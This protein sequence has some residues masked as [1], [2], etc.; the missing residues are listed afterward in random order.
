MNLR[1]F[2][3]RLQ[4]IDKHRRKVPLRLNWAQDDYISRIEQQYDSGRPGRFIILKARQMGLSTAT[5]AVL[6]VYSFLFENNKSLVIS[7]NQ[8][9]YEH[10]LS[11]SKH[12]WETFWAKRL[13]TTDY[14]SR[15][16]LAWIETGSS[17]RTATAKTVSAGRS[18]TIHSL[19]ASE[20]GFWDDAATLMTG[21]RQTIP[22][23][24]SS[25]IALESTANGIGNYFH[26]EW[27]AAVRG[28]SEYI[29]LFYPW[30]KHPEYT[31]E[32]IHTP[33]TYIGPLS[34]DER[35]LSILLSST[36]S[37]TPA[38]IDSRIIWRRHAIRNLCQNDLSIFHQEYPATPEE[39]FISTGRNVFPYADLEQCYQRQVGHRGFI[40]N[41][42]TGVP[43][44][45]P[46]P[47]GPCTIFS[48]PSSNRDYGRYFVAGDP[49]HTTRGDYACIQVINRRTLEQVARV[50]IKIDPVNFAKELIN[51]AKFY[52][53]AMISCES[54]GPG[55][56]TIGAILTMGYPNVWQNRFADKLQGAMPDQYGF[57]TNV[58][59]KNWAIGA[60]LNLIVEHQIIIHDPI[61]FDELTN[62]ISLDNGTYGP[63]SSNG[64]DDTVMALAIAVI[65]HLTEPPLPPMGQ[66]TPSGAPWEDW[67]L[68]GTLSEAFQNL[69]QGL[70][71][72]AV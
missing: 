13:F 63:A 44:F 5:E 57:A 4:I 42:G 68:D 25:F 19:H 60:L 67:H 3:Q 71:H 50:R 6:F 51:V 62:Y 34:A 2:I 41:D 1:P 28:D 43:R 32:M 17:I 22:D 69:N 54:T 14:K 29:P 46:S 15:R 18:Q 40:I 27:Q 49:T 47:E 24:P 59:R 66:D 56:A 31:A 21:L 52:N 37:Y 23:T 38:Q 70:D 9:S 20:V 10:L 58:Q 12:Y 35:A 55:Y 33:T 72:A 39:A 30:W 48:A 45:T 53:N 61:T 64:Y 16:E 26:S 11:M 8:D 65:C 7:H 36:A